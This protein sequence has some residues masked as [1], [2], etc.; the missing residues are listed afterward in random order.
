[1]T[2]KVTVDA[3]AGWPV[4]VTPVNNGLPDLARKATV[5]PGDVRDFYVHSGNDLLIHEVQQNE[6][7][8]DQTLGQY[9]VGITFNPSGDGMVH[10][11]KARAAAL[12]DLISLIPEHSG[13]EV[14]RIKALAMTAA[15]DA[16]MWAVK[17]ATKPVRGG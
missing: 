6:A 1:M 4:D 8:Q 9:R 17:A 3:H 10:Q 5:S 7:E 14:P 15:E 12:I 13:G 16:A 11:I 2:T